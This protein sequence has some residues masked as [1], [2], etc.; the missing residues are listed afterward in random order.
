MGAQGGGNWPGG[1]TIDGY[2][3]YSYGNIKLTSGQ[4][5]YIY[6]GQ[7]AGTYN[8]GGI[9]AAPGGGATHIA[10]TNR[11]ELKTYLSYQ[12][13]VAIVAAGGGGLEWGGK[14]GDGGG[15]IGNNGIRKQIVIFLRL[16]VEQVVL[17][18]LV[19]HLQ[20]LLLLFIVEQV[21]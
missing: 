17:N 18:P 16:L 11:G 8:G 15:T 10:M 5:M 19:E 21:H 7:S 1:N 4:I 12:S 2:G 6:V 13:E 3:G 14:G 20:Y 9:G